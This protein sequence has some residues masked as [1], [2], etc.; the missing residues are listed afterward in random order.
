MWL[1]ARWLLFVCFLWAYKWLINVYFAL[2]SFWK[3]QQVFV[4]SGLAQSKQS[5]WMKCPLKLEV[6]RED[7]QNK[8]HQPNP[9]LRRW[10]MQ[11]LWPIEKDFIYMVSGTQCQDSYGLKGQMCFHFSLRDYHNHLASLV[12]GQSVGSSCSM[13]CSFLDHLCWRRSLDKET[14]KFFL[15]QITVVTMRSKFKH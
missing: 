6:Q 15:I 1:L 10:H 7:R 5:I 4:N 3:G 13:S 9:G 8:A 12:M 11:C 2:S 14:L